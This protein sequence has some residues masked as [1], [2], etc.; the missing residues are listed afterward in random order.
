MRTTPTYD[1]DLDTARATIDA[2][3]PSVSFGSE[4][5]PAPRPLPDP[6]PA[7]P[8]FDLELVPA[9]LRP[10]V[11]DAANGLQVPPE[12]VAVPAIVAAAGV[13]G[14]QVGVALKVHER[15]IERCILWGAI[16]G[17]PSSG[18]I[19]VGQA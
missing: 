13:I 19:Q 18:R 16:V 4:Q 17:R 10:W 5:N 7:V 12:F 11:T 9:S 2:M 15:W 14:R 8:A 6:L 1:A 3:A